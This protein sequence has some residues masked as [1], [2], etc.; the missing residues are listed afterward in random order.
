[1]G[2]LRDRSTVIAALLLATLAFAGVVAESHRHDSLATPTGHEDLP[3]FAVGHEQPDH[4]V[5][6]EGAT[7][8]EAATC[9]GC[10]QR[11][12]QRVAGMPEPVLG[13]FGP[14]SSAIAKASAWRPAAEARRLKDP[15]APPRA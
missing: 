3:T 14:G 10:L 5:H 6:I 1:M 11:Q 7:R 12:R 15:R 13:D 9:V 4:T 2:V 8:I